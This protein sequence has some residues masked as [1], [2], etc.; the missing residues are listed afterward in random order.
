MY[1]ASSHVDALAFTRTPI[2]PYP[3]MMRLR[4]MVRPALHRAGFELH[5][6]PDCEPAHAR[7]LLIRENLID[8]VLDVGANDG[9]FGREARRYG[10]DGEIVSFE[11]VSDPRIRLTEGLTDELWTV[12]DYG[13]ADFN[14]E[15][16]INVASNGGASSS[17]LPMLERHSQ[18]APS[19]AYESTETCNVRTL[20]SIWSQYAARRV[21]LKIDVQGFERQVLLGA[22]SSLNEVTGIQMEISFSPLYDG[23]MLWREGLDLL[24]SYGFEVQRIDPGFSDLANGQM[25][26]ADAV[27]FR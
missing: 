7:G 17:A 12:M 15:I 24:D 23:G 18:A 1:S 6:W 14:G 26:Q 11:P 19:V 9:A 10:Y 2:L 27:L 8:C 25:L 13:L 5:R 20:D 4:E 16:E 22:H 21:Y 3:W